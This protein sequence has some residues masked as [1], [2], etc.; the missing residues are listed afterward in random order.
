M[1]EAQVN[2][3]DSLRFPYW[4]SNLAV[5]PL[6]NLMSS[7]AFTLCWPFLPL[8]LQGLGVHSHIET[9]I[10][11]MLLVFYAVSFVSAPLW[12][13]IADYYGRKIMILRA[14]LGMGFCMALVPF[15]QTPMW[16]AFLVALVGM[17][18]GAVPS[19]VSLLV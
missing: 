16:F 6:V 9:W 10:G 11:N 15:A 12:G 4:R 19:V 7:M 1:S 17:F 13:G 14:V 18:N 5:L 2:D 3:E 8:I